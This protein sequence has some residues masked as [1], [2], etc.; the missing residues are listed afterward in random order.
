MTR[1]LGIAI[2]TVCAVFAAGGGGAPASAEEFDAAKLLFDGSKVLMEQQEIDA[3]LAA[4][5][6]RSEE[7]KLDRQRMNQQAGQINSDRQ[8]TQ[9]TCGTAAYYYTHRMDCDQSSAELSTRSAEAGDK[10]DQV[11]RQLQATSSEVE[12]LTARREQ[13]KRQ[14]EALEL[15][16][17]RLELSGMTQECVSRLPKDNLESMVAAYQECWDGTSAAEPRLKPEKKKKL[18]PELEPESAEIA[19]KERKPRRSPPPE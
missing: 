9:D 2:M 14:S 17:K 4:M 13:L 7:M 15:K 8:V 5:Q 18:K 12:S 6:A 10:R 19:P 11:G 1:Y 16:F 3:K